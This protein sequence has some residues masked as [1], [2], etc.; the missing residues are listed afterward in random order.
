[1]FVLIWDYNMYN[2]MSL[3]WT[4]GD[5][6]GHDRFST[7]RRIKQLIRP[8]LKDYAMWVL[9]KQKDQDMISSYAIS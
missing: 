5:A 2:G 9:H 8:K 7:K 6:L 4:V 3:Y 1:M